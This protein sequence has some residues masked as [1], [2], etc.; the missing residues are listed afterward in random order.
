MC[1][2][3]FVMASGGMLD[4]TELVEQL[5]EEKDIIP[6]ITTIESLHASHAHDELDE[7]DGSGGKNGVESQLDVGIPATLNHA[8]GKKNDS[9]EV[10]KVIH[11]G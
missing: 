3:I 5:G 11:V 2:E 7:V 1:G 8:D 6:R 10:S 4:P 9:C